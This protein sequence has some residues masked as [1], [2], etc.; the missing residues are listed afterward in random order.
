[1]SLGYNAVHVSYREEQDYDALASEH[2]KHAATIWMI[3]TKRTKPDVMPR[4]VFVVVSK[5]VAHGVWKARSE[6]QSER[7]SIG[8]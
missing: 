8:S 6:V 5:A 7:L 3:A 1:M 2:A 4:N